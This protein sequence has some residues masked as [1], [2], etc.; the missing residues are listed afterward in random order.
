MRRALLV[1]VIALAATTAFVI[2]ERAT[3]RLNVVVGGAVAVI[4][5]PLLLL[6]RVQ[7]GRAFSVAPKATSLVTGGIY[8]K[9]PHPMYVFLDLFLLG[10]VIAGRR[11]WLVGVWLALVA[12]QSWQAGREANVLEQAFGDGYRKYRAQTWW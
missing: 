4:G 5:L 11:Q 2:I 12:V 7:L 6:S 8:S 10:L 9:I 3:D 1:V